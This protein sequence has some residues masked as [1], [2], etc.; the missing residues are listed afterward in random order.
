MEYNIVIYGCDN[1]GK[2][3]LAKNLVHNLMDAFVESGAREEGAE[4]A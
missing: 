3:T 2:T 1:S 4:Y